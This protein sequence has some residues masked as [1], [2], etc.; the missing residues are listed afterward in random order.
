M[1]YTSLILL[2]LFLFT[3]CQSKE[4]EQ[5]A[6]HVQLSTSID[7]LVAEYRNLGIFSGIV[8]VA[9][10]GIPFYHKAYG[11]AKRKANIK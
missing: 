10:E 11:E 8:L 3:S 7:D 5:P 1:N 9:E 4:P 6:P 2:C